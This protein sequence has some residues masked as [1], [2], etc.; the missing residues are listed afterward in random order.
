MLFVYTKYVYIQQF[1]TS[2]KIAAAIENTNA[3]I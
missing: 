3:S 1:N 2:Q